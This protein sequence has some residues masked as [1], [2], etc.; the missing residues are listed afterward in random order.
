VALTWF[1]FFLKS[2]F[3]ERP[4]RTWGPQVGRLVALL[5]SRSP[6]PFPLSSS[7]SFT[8]GFE[9]VVPCVDAHP[10]SRSSPHSR[11]RRWPRQLS[12]LPCFSAIEPLLVLENIMVRP[13][14]PVS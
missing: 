5:N 13:C 1:D 3:I 14:R 11:A 2:I 6:L 4:V 8:P 7:P 10:W 12:L 9:L